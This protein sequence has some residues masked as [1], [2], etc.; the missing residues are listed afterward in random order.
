MKPLTHAKVFVHLDDGT[1]V[2]TGAV[3][4]FDKGRFTPE[5]IAEFTVLMLQG[6]M[7]AAKKRFG[8]RA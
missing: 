5:E 7:D 6:D 4:V 1:Q 8:D 3:A 2:D